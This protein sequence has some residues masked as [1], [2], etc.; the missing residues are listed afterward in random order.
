M[1]KM[2][3]RKYDVSIDG[4]RIRTYADFNRVDMTKPERRKHYRKMKLEKKDIIREEKTL[5]SV[6]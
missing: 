4:Y 3:Q 5:F 6:S 2:R 1:K